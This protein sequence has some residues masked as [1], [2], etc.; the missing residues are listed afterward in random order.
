M[1]LLIRVVAFIAVLIVGLIGIGFLLADKVHV[2][3]SA[4]MLATPATVYAVVNSFEKFD[5]WSPWA[6]LDPNM[7]VVRSGPDSGVG[8]KYAWHGNAEAGSGTQ[9]IIE[10]TPDEMV[11]IRL[12]FDGFD[13]PSMST[14]SIK[15]EGNGSL[16]TWSLDSDMGGNPVHRY[17]GLMM[18]K[19]VGQDYEKGLAKL[20]TLAES[21]PPAK[22]TV[23]TLDE[24]LPSETP[25]EAAPATTPTPEA[26]A[27]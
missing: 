8:A 7:K 2:E 24:A 25:A 23:P 19:Y 14:L 13:Q 16:V 26:A 21:L 4:K 20:K 27:Y 12:D 5:Q 17:F 9:E 11:S 3:R 10:S 22:S 6:E 18:E 15:P 1:R